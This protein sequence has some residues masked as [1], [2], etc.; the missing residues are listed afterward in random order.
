MASAKQKLEC[1]P[2]SPCLCCPGSYSLALA[3]A[4]RCE[5]TGEP[6]AALQFTVHQR[7]RFSQTEG[8]WLSLSKRSC[9]IMFP[10]AFAYSMFLHHSL[11]TLAIVCLNL[12]M[13]IAFVMVIGHRSSVLLPL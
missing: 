13:I 4:E 11:G 10:I 1:E 9:D 12:S 8:L 7:L 3:D 6:L 2:A 5:S